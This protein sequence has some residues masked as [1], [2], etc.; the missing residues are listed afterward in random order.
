MDHELCVA[1][2][3]KIAS[4]SAQ[5]NASASTISS[6]IPVSGGCINSTEIISLHSGDKFFVKSNREHPELFATE[7]SGLQA[8]R[9][10]QTIRVPDYHG[11]GKTNDGTGFL[12]LEFIETG[13]GS[14]D[15]FEKFGRLLASMHLKSTKISRNYQFGL[16]TNNFIGC[17]PQINVPS[18]DWP[19]FFA[20][21]R[22]G[23][24]LKLAVDAGLSSPELYRLCEQLINKLPSLIGNS[25]E[26]PALIHGDLWSGNYLASSTGEPVLIDPAVY[27]GPREAEFGMTMLFGGFNSEFYQAYNEAFPLAVDWEE[28][29]EIYKLYHLLNHLN[30][31]GTSY[32]SDCLTILRKFC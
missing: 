16:P 5:T 25:N 7:V 10:T 1:V 9:Q 21:Q 30:L 14:V 6:S 28:R 12:I 8:I 19:T 15:F 13:T 23:F 32:L 17:S 31:F 26:P 2:E 3:K 20:E 18:N 4:R 29:V 24:Q 22:I 27:F 11:H